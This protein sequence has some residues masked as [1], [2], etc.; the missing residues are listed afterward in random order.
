MIASG[1]ENMITI[2]MADTQGSL[3]GATALMA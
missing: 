2:S 3:Y 1:I